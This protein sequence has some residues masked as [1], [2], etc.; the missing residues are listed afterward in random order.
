MIN[1]PYLNNTTLRSRNIRGYSMRIS[2][3]TCEH[4]RVPAKIREE[5]QP[6]FTNRL[7]HCKNG[8]SRLRICKNGISRLQI[9]KISAP[10]LFHQRIT[11]QKYCFKSSQNIFHTLTREIK[12][13]FSKMPLSDFP[14]RK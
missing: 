11:N 1:W 10:I 8:I 7:L 9:C 14:S 2:A 5:K 4:S 12:G 6:V 3:I 13:K